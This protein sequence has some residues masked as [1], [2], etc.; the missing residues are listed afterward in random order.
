M[1]ELEYTWLTD[2]TPIHSTCPRT[3]QIHDGLKCGFVDTELR[4]G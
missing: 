4:Q 2:F 1:V 3:H